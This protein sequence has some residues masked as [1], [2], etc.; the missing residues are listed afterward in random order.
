MSLV[1][2]KPRGSNGDRKAWAVAWPISLGIHAVA[3]TVLY[4]MLSPGSEG[5]GESDTIKEVRFSEPEPILE[6]R[7]KLA[8]ESAPSLGRLLERPTEDSMPVEE[9]GGQLS[10]GPSVIGLG[11]GDNPLGTAAIFPTSSR[12]GAPQV[13]FFGSTA[14]GYKIVFVVDRS[15]SMWD[16]FDRVQDEL[17]NALARLGPNQQFEL[18]FF[19]SGE[20][21]QMEPVGLKAA[22][23]SN[24][25]AAYDFLQH[26]GRMD[27]PS[28]PTDPGPALLAGLALPSGPADAIFLLSDG[29]F[30]RKV[31]ESVRQVNPSGRTRI[32]TLGFGYKAG[33]K[34]LKKLARGNGGSFRFVEIEELAGGDDDSLEALLR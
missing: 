29:D 4:L 12:A 30:P 27:P 33:G 18:I 14:A 20:P 26:I 2:R 21:E 7:T 1:W 8:A 5:Q 6:E 23:P 11:S 32:N 16:Q 31:L 28:G 15:G 17:L 13:S 19:T 22:T 34:L 3:L 24:R 25:Q 10:A 9:L